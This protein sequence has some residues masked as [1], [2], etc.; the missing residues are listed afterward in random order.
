MVFASLTFLFIFLPLCLITYYAF[1]QRQVRNVI[2]I[3]FS[4]FFYAWGEP[5]WVSLLIISAIWDYFNGLWIGRHL[6]NPFLAKV[7]ILSSL[8]VNL[9]LLATFKY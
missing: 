1:P 5:I 3:I 2:L 6:D 4:L 7:G 8:T 9:G